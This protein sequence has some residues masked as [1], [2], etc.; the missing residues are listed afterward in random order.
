MGQVGL[1]AEPTGDPLSDLSVHLSLQ[2]LRAPEGELGPQGFLPGGHLGVDLRA[3]REGVELPRFQLADDEVGEGV[4]PR[5]EV[6][7][8]P[9][10][11]RSDMKEF[12][13]RP[14]PD[15]VRIPVADLPEETAEA[16][17]AERP[18]PEPRGIARA[19][20]GPDPVRG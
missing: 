12:A 8:H 2:R 7:A 16:R 20:G 15:V 17:I 6:L 5:R 11:A 9:A 10:R 4:V 18:L 1:L 19:R 3:D 13:D 14:T